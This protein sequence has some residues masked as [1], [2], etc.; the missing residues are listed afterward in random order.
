LELAKKHAEKIKYIIVGLA[1]TAIDFGILFLLVHFGVDKII[2]NY[3]STSIA[4]IFIFFVNRSFTFK[5]TSDNKKKQFLLFIV[6]TL[7][8][9]WVLQPIVITLVSHIIS[10]LFSSALVLFIAKVIAT[11]VSL[12]WNYIFYS[13]IVFKKAE[14]K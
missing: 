3:I 1:N 10:S 6:V 5:S 2:A 11:G 9:L 7:F 4:L 12:D 14:E 8:G 13:R